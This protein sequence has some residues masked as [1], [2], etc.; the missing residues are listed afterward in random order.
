[1]KKRQ[2][3]KYQK[4]AEELGKRYMELIHHHTSRLTIKFTNDLFKLQN[5]YFSQ[6]NEETN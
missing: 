4:E 2:L 6:K 5:K 3:N 1:M